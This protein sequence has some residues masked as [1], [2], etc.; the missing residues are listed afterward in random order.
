MELMVKPVLSWIISPLAF[1]YGSGGYNLSPNPP[2]LV[3]VKFSQSHPSFAPKAA[4]PRLAALPTM[5]TTF[6]RWRSGP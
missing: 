5:S 2:A 4:L 1:M 6:H 3:N